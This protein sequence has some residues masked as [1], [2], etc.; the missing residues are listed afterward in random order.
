MDREKVIALMNE[1]LEGEHGAIIQYLS[2]AYAM[3][4][5]EMACEI[6]AIAREEMRHL[7]WLAETIVELGGVP[8]LK[9][10]N[11]RTGG[12]SVA[13]WM[14]KN[15]L[16]EED[17]VGLYREHIKKIDDPRI[18]RLLK[19]I[20]SDEE[21][22]HGD[23]KHFVDKAKRE[24]AKD[25]R[26]SRIDKVIRTLNW[27]VEHEYTVILQ[28]MFQSYMTTNEE[29]KKELEDQA[30][31]E[32]QHLGWLAEK[33]VDI[34]GNPVIEHTEVDRSTKTTDMLQADIDIE[35]KVAT[36]YDRA[37]KEAEDPKLKELLL[38]LRDHELYHADVFGDLLKEE[39]K[40]PE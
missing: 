28:Y 29:A 7:D 2:H 33:I 24:G 20:L 23:F 31:N 26:G 6:E 32:M 35:K 9:R 34:S 4:E 12:T 8:S 17:A 10:G 13:D 15:V 39:E 1:D 16:L 21:S 22:H 25:V 3:G 38:R 27:G 19:R 40:N 11:M 30:I 37:A 14:A 36:E 5:G 18:K